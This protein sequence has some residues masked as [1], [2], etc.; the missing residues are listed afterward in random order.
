MYLTRGG[1]VQRLLTSGPR[2]WPIGQVLCRFD[3]WLCAHKKG[4]AMAVEKFGGG[5]T[6]W[7][8]GQL[9]RPA[10]HHLVSYRFNQVGTPSLDPYK[11]PSVGGNQNTHHILEIP[12]AKH[13]FLV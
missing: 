12:L 13:P 6:T 11:Y 2:G 9:A 1:S 3:P 5:Q 8:P 4:K 7:P 10:G